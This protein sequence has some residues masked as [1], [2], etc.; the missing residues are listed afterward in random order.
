MTFEDFYWVLKGKKLRISYYIISAKKNTLIKKNVKVDHTE[1]YTYH[2]VGLEKLFKNHSLKTGGYLGN[3]RLTN[4]S[5]FVR[6][7][8][9]FIGSYNCFNSCILTTIPTDKII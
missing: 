6:K 1:K 8:L 5:T 3:I 2:F 4:I 9:L 7:L